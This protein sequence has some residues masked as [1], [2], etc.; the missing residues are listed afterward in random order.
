[1]FHFTLPRSTCYRFRTEACIDYCYGSLIWRNVQGRYDENLQDSIS[2]DFVDSVVAQIHKQVVRWVRIHPMGDFLNDFYFERWC[3]IARRCPKTRFLA[4]T[5]N[6]EIDGSITPSN[7]VLYFTVDQTTIKDNP[8]IKRRA[9]A[10]ENYLKGKEYYKHFSVLQ[11]N[12]EFRICSNRC[13]N[14]RAC[15]FG[16]IDIAFPIFR[17]GRITR[18]PPGEKYHNPRNLKPRTLVYPS[19]EAMP[20][21]R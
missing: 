15:W 11:D 16:T 1:V 18:K 20:P 9:Y 8:T 6:H 2:D 4:Y 19:Y 14:C 7:F 5:R 12:K 13:A 10:F 3:E 21:L 17:G